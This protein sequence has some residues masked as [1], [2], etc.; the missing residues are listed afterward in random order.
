M[1]RLTQR[2]NKQFAESATL[3]EAIHKNLK[4]DMNIE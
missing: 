1:K 2:L 4:V 3:E